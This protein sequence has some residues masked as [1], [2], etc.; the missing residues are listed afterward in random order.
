MGEVG[1]RTHSWLVLWVCWSLA[2]GSATQA[3]LPRPGGPRPGRPA[4]GGPGSCRS[5]AA[6]SPGTCPQAYGLME[7]RRAGRPSAVQSCGSG[8]C[9][10]Q[11][12]ASVACKIPVSRT[13]QILG[14]TG[15]CSPRCRNVQLE[16]V[17]GDHAVWVPG[18]SNPTASS[19]QRRAEGDSTRSFHKVGEPGSCKI[20][21]SLSGRRFA[22]CTKR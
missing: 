16:R 8:E 3:A 7:R 12:R 13:V 9:L 18:G 11:G 1:A 5:R 19:L 6:P 2:E 4:A 21:S 17:P 15:I 14:A 10:A 20:C 22:I